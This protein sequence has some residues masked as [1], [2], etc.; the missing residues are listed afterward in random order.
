MANR[1]HTLAVFAEILRMNPMTL[2]RILRELSAAGFVPR[3]S[4]GKRS[5]HYQLDALVNVVLALAA[6]SPSEAAAA[7]RALSTLVYDRERSTQRFMQVGEDRARFRDLIGRYLEDFADSDHAAKTLE[8]LREARASDRAVPQITMNLDPLWACITLP[9]ENPA[10]ADEKQ[11]YLPEDAELLTQPAPAGWHPFV[12]D[13]DLLVTAGQLY[14]DTL[15]RQTATLIPDSAPGSAGEG[16]ATPETTKASGTGIREGLRSEQPAP[17][18]Q[19]A[20]VNKAQF[21]TKEGSK[22]R[23]LNSVVPRSQVRQPTN[24]PATLRSRHH[25]SD[26]TVAASP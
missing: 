3:V 24:E 10:Y 1:S 17:K 11:W 5:P 25:G 7:V 9:P 6:E 19:T 13:Y 8:D 12:M 16:E 15:A 4:P 20:P 26:W 2:D 14:A 18:A 23:L 21:A 22:Q